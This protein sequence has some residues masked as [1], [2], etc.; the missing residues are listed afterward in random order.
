[1]LYPRKFL[2]IVNVLINRGYHGDLIAMVDEPSDD[3]PPKVIYVPGSI[4]YQGDM[5]A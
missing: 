5:P 1:M 3:V 4:C 2:L